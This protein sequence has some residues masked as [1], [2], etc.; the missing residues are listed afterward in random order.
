MEREQHRI[1]D[2]VSIDGIM[3]Y[4]HVSSVLQ[5]CFDRWHWQGKNTSHWFLPMTTVI[6]AYGIFNTRTREQCDNVRS[7]EC[8][9]S[10]HHRKAGRSRLGVGWRIWLG[11][12][13][14]MATSEKFSR[15]NRTLP[16]C[17]KKLL[18]KHSRHECDIVTGV[19]RWKGERHYTWLNLHLLWQHDLKEA[20]N[21]RSPILLARKFSGGILL[22]VLTGRGFFNIHVGNK[23]FF[24]IAGGFCGCTRR[25]NRMTLSELPVCELCEASFWVLI[26]REILKMHQ[27]AFPI[28][29]TS[30]IVQNAQNVFSWFVQLLLLQLEQWRTCWFVPCRRLPRRPLGRRCD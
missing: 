11:D 9:G 17:A 12:L 10:L 6:V 22:T 18:C 21:R 7:I 13:F 1:G 20:R 4:A 23:P 24:S 5:L 26:Q 8:N 29:T 19:K 15:D 27:I 2:W 30:R 28:P 14:R 16:C 25:A 3:T